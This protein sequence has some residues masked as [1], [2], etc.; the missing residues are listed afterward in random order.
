MM[1]PAVPAGAG[2]HQ[3]R[4]LSVLL[5]G[6]MSSNTRQGGMKF[7][8]QQEEGHQQLLGCIVGLP[9]SFCRQAGW[10]SGK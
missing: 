2:S 7:L 5:A 9:R 10:W 3:Q 8:K 6:T 1:V 4:C